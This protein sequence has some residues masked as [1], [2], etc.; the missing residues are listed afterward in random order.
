MRVDMEHI[1][2]L[3]STLETRSNNYERVE[4]TLGALLDALLLEPEAEAL[5]R[6]PAPLL[7]QALPHQVRTKA[8]AAAAAAA[9]TA[10]C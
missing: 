9:A 5:L 3:N 10:V 8:A 2:R 6:A 1:E 7:E 4:G